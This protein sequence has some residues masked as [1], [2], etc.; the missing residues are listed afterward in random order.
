MSTVGLTVNVIIAN[1]H[2]YWDRHVWDVPITA[3]TG[4]SSPD[5]SLDTQLISPRRAQG[6]LLCKAYLRLRFHLHSPIITVLLLPPRRRFRHQVVRLGLA[7]NRFPQR[8]SRHH[9]HL[10]RYLAMQVSL[11]IPTS[12][13][14]R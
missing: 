7:R 5:F 9:L 11:P 14:P 10:S 2:Y 3:F 13:P 12:V 4:A 8:S 1:K 6:C